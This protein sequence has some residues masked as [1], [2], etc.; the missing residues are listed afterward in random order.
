M[1]SFLSD[2]GIQVEDND[3]LHLSIVYRNSNANN[4]ESG[5]LLQGKQ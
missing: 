4:L 2:S 5:I 1:V 3:R